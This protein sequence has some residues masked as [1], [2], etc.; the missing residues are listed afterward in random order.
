MLARDGRRVG[1]SQVSRPLACS[2]RINGRLNRLGCCRTERNPPSEACGGMR[3]CLDCIAPP[4]CSRLRNRRA[5]TLAPRKRQG[6][7]GETTPL[8]PCRCHHK[9]GCNGKECP[10]S[11]QPGPRTLQLRTTSVD[12][13][14]RQ[15]PQPVSRYGTSRQSATV[16]WLGCRGTGPIR[17]SRRE[18]T[19]AT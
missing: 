19:Y 4:E 1:S 10:P 9:G 7:V 12:R 15:G 17:W 6:L 16:P 8:R 3:Y 11:L 2:S 5:S 18:R 14:A 13:W